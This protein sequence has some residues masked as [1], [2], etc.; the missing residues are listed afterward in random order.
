MAAGLA[1][2]V[3][4]PYRSGFRLDADTMALLIALA[5]QDL[6]KTLRVIDL[7]YKLDTEEGV[8]GN[9][10]G[11]SLT[12]GD[13]S[14]EEDEDGGRE[15]NRRRD[16]RGRSFNHPLHRGTYFG[17]AGTGTRYDL[18]RHD[19]PESTV[20]LLV[21]LYIS[22]PGCEDRWV[23]IVCQPSRAKLVRVWDCDSGVGYAARWDVIKP[24][25]RKLIAEEAWFGVAGGPDVELELTR[26]TIAPT[27]HAETPAD[28]GEDWTGFYV[29]IWLQECCYNWRP[30]IVQ[31]KDRHIWKP[32]PANNSHSGHWIDGNSPP[33]GHLSWKAVVRC[34]L[35]KIEN[36][37]GF[38]NTGKS[39][40]YRKKVLEQVAPTTEPLK[41]GGGRFRD[42]LTRWVRF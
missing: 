31:Y 2:N 24:T 3:R 1:S 14:A 20:Q 42:R 37:R 30:R 22:V 28:E 34:R 7:V 19:I 26:W 38:Q 8:D 29:W 40:V 4:G 21:A 35:E 16:G 36:Q 12:L 5:N 9:D 23:G 15:D 10:W 18:S 25:V 27:G 39:F 11:E 33:P 41:K 13:S 32:L 6:G 17:M